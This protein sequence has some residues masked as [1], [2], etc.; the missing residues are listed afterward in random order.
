[1][2]E[3]KK[4]TQFQWTVIALS[5]TADVCSSVVDSRK[6]PSRTSPVGA[7]FLLPLHP[8]TKLEVPLSFVPL[9]RPSLIE[10]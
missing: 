1:M 10:T 5:D 2:K 8:A 6:V 9:S 3:R 4:D 7:Y